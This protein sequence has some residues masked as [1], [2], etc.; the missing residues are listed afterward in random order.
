MKS[1]LKSSAKHYCLYVRGTGSYEEIE[2][3]STIREMMWYTLED[4]PLN[5]KI[6]VLDDYL[7]NANH[8]TEAS[9]I[10]RRE[11]GSLLRDMYESSHSV[12]EL[13]LR[14]VTSDNWMI[15]SIG[16]IACSKKV[17]EEI[18]VI[19]RNIIINRNNPMS[20]V[21]LSDLYLSDR[22]YRQRYVQP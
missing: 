3:C 12:R 2:N 1:I 22:T 11:I 20:L 13:V 19:L 18:A 21:W 14:Y 7:N 5:L 10:V 15:T 4:F 8:L 16:I 9:W 17:D 6:K